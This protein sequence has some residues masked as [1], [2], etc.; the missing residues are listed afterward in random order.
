M[1]KDISLFITYYIN[2][3]GNRQSY[4][5]ADKCFENLI[6]PYLELYTAE[7]FI[8]LI[9]KINT[10]CQLNQRWRAHG[11]NTEIYRFAKKILPVDFDYSQYT[12]FK[13][14]ADDSD[15]IQDTDELNDDGQLLF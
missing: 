5:G 4:D 9:E 13:Y 8:Q 6:E 12:N 11:N 14:N 3:F 1:G 2:L 10:N 15:L 7:Q